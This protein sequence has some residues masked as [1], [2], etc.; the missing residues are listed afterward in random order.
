MSPQ[1]QPDHAEQITL[2]A[3]ADAPSRERPADPRK[4]PLSISE[5]YTAVLRIQRG[6]RQ[7][8]FAQFHGALKK[9]IGADED[10]SRRVWPSFRDNP[11]GWLECRQPQTQA[12][13]LIELILDIT[14]D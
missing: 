7:M 2:A 3:T 1:T 6:V 11:T 9:T 12:I 8:T 5:A 10:Y 4:M 13:E 14:K